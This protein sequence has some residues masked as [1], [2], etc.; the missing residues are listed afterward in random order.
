VSGYALIITDTASEQ[1]TE[2]EGWWRAN[3]PKA[4]DRFMQEMLDALDHIAAMPE[5]TG[6]KYEASRVPGVRRYILRR[7]RY[8]VY[9]TTNREARAVTVR[10]IWHAS[11]GRGPEL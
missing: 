10:A 7:S 4:P 2:E 3:R 8:H 6:A 5:G 1:I 11:R 9:Y